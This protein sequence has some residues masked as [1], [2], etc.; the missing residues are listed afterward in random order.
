VTLSLPV[1]TTTIGTH[2]LTVFTTDPNG[3]ADEVTS[4]DTL[5]KTFAVYEPVATPISEN[6]ENTAFPTPNWGVQNV[7]GGT[8]F[9]RATNAAQSGRGSIVINNSD[10]RNSNGAIDYFISP[11][12][13]NFSTFDSMHVDFDLAYRPGVRY[14]GST[15]F[16]LDTL[17]LMATKDCG[18]TF[19]SVWKSWGDKLQTLN[20]PNYATNTL[21]TPRNSN[22]WKKV[23]VYLSPF[24]GSDNFQLYFTMIGNRQNSL[25]MD[26][27]NINS[28]KLS[29]RLKDQGYLIYPN[30]FNGSFL[31]HHSAVEP[32]VD[33]QAVQIFNPAGQL[34]WD[35]RYNGT[36]ER[37][38]NVDLSSKARGLYILK[39]MYT[40]K[41]VIERIVKN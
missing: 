28:T 35:K 32:P 20:D 38:I 7:T 22:E 19:I 24:V 36:A 23:R 11:I 14:P 34:V 37:R 9:Q 33:L 26:N 3:A 18:Q 25:W 13:S 6:F 2:V 39:M 29:Q 21:F 17:E 41:T 12:V 40:N 1:G 30:P 16:Q 27:I 10:S 5:R 4:N 8:T 15:V 31:I